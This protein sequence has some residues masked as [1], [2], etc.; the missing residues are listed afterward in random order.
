[1]DGVGLVAAAQFTKPGTTDPDPDTAF[2]VYQK[3]VES[4]VML[5]SPVGVGGCCIKINPPLTITREALVEGLKVVE[6]AVAEGTKQSD[7]SV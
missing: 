2:E 3:C 1:M 4:G 7:R 5:F 6:E